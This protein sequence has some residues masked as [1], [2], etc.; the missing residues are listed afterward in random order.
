M[1]FY[2]IRHGLSVGN[3]DPKAYYDFLDCDIPLTE[4]G[5][6]QAQKVGWDLSYMVDN[7]FYTAVFYTP[8]LR[9]KQTKDE[10]MKNLFRGKYS[11]RYAHAQECPLLHERS[12]G[13]LREIIDS[14]QV[15]EKVHYN[16]F[17]RP[18]GGESLCDCYHR[19]ATFFQFVKQEHSDREH[20]IIVAHGE[21]IKCGLMYLLGWSIDEFNSY[22][23]PDN[24]EMIIVENG[25]LKTKLRKRKT[26][27]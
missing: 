13:N 26:V 21:S 20:I 11:K 3:V 25:E 17:Y 22:C 4:L 9:G 15:D 16:F 8:F 7:P 2:L 12:F 19:M 24:C 1:T 23:N 10:I 5:V 6:E 27:E 18:E 14:Q